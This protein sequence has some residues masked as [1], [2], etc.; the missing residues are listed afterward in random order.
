MYFILTDILQQI[1]NSP[2]K[3]FQSD[4]H[5][6]STLSEIHHSPT[7][8]NASEHQI[9]FAFSKCP[10]FLRQSIPN[11]RL[12]AVIHAHCNF[13]PV[14]AR[15]APFI[16]MLKCHMFIIWC[17]PQHKWTI[18]KPFLAPAL[19]CAADPNASKLFVKSIRKQ[20]HLFGLTASTPA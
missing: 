8:S 10:P 7:K 15:S 3:S 20:I 4:Y 11:Y 2:T 6:T 16:P 19:V 5:A 9:T 12:S 18:P 13:V 14:T 17:I 1:L